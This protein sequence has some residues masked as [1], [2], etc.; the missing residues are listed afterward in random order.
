MSDSRDLFGDEE[1][2][3][4]EGMP[5]ESQSEPSENE[6]NPEEENFVDS[7]LNKKKRKR[8]P[9][10]DV[11][12]DEENMVDA[13][14]VDMERAADEDEEANEK[15]M[16]AL[17]KLKMLDRVLKFLRVSKY[18]EL[19]L[20][21]NGTV[22]L[23][24]WL[25]QLPDGSFPCAPIKTG[26]LKAI[27]DLNFSIENLQNSNLGK[28]VYA[29]SQNPNEHASIKKLAKSLVDKWARTIFD[30]TTDYTNLEEAERNMED[31]GLTDKALKS[32][33]NQPTEPTS[34]TR[35]PDRGMFVFKY[36]P[37]GKNQGMR[38][39]NRSVSGGEESTTVRLK[40]KMQ[41]KKSGKRKAVGQ[42]SVDGRNLI[43]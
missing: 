10:W 12:D 38:Q 40:K 41:R 1:S 25:G 22:P 31:I 34:Y 39:S 15:G 43:I 27:Y 4:M 13:L 36:R 5:Q 7:I 29:I 3:Q 26:L 30:I 19:F 11:D 32:G 9:N 37:E 24:R 8:N 21:M 14:L 2:D 42:M 20:N 28:S 35:I 33:K 17:S 18:H 23:G 16:P 6:Q